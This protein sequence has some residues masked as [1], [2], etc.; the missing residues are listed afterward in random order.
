MKLTITISDLKR[1]ETRSGAAYRCTLHE[2][3]VGST[4]TYETTYKGCLFGVGK[5]NRAWFLPPMSR[6][7]RGAQ[8][9]T[10]LFN[11]SKQNLL[12]EHLNNRKLLE[13]LGKEL[14]PSFPEE[15]EVIT[16]DLS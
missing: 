6:T 5:E 8:I 2:S 3:L 7:A 10:I 13:G 9:A 1:V 11:E 4:E 14:S 16:I 12:L 15:S